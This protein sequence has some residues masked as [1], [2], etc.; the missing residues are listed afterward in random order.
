MRHAVGRCGE[1]HIEWATELNLG[2]GVGKLGTQ[3][4]R[5]S[6]S[7]T[8]EGSRDG[9]ARLNRN[10]DESHNNRKLCVDGAMDPARC[11]SESKCR[12][13]SRRRAPRRREHH[14]GGPRGSRR[15]Q[16]GTGGRTHHESE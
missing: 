4:A 14:Y 12:I 8:I 7:H 5:S 9:F 3:S 10:G 2:H 6:S 15:S 11:S 1:R 13:P 16:N